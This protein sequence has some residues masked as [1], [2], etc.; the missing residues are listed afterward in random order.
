M[1][2]F[3][4]DEARD[5]FARAAREQQAA[6]EATATA[7]LTLDELQEIGRAS[8]LDPAFVARAAQAVALGKPETHRAAL[9]PVPTA[10]GRTVRLAEAPSDALWERLVADARRTF[11]AKGR[12]VAAGAER[13]WRNSNLRVTL[14][15]DGSGSR[16]AVETRRTDVAPFLGL[17][18]FVA[19]AGTL[20]ALFGLRGGD[21]TAGMLA[22]TLSLAVAGAVWARQRSWAA[23]RERQM[24]EITERAGASVASPVAE[25][26][27]HVAA[28]LLDL[29]ALGDPLDGA[30]EAEPESRRRT[31]S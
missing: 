22:L 11:R 18:A 29:D 5:V 23:T 26:P 31:R 16:L 15:P 6:H 3:T 25:A 1:R 24:Q 9:G 4:E 20:S 17:A 7:G 14:A 19:L 2:T 28:P 13:E 8:G 10:V 12:I 21:V 27:P 30:S